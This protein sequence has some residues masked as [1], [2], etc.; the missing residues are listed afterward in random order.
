MFLGVDSVF[1]SW[2]CVDVGVDVIVDVVV[3][4]IIHRLGA[5]Q[6]QSIRSMACI[7]FHAAVHTFLSDNG[8]DWSIRMHRL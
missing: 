4:R 6:R 7:A 3:R 2:N 1:L 8:V 5:Y